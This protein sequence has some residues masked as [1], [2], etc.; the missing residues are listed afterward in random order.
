MILM[1]D[2]IFTVLL[3]FVLNYEHIR[4]TFGTKT[5]YLLMAHNYVTVDVFG[6][7]WSLYLTVETYW[8][9]SSINDTKNF[10][11]Q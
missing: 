6:P 5:C 1:S 9:C 4:G 10:G 11:L 7:K 2:I 8:I 3:F